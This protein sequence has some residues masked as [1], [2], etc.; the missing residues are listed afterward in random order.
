MEGKTVKSISKLL[1]LTSIFVFVLVLGLSLGFSIGGLGKDT[2]VYATENTVLDY[3]NSNYPTVYV[4]NDEELRAALT[5]EADKLVVVNKDITCESVIEDGSY[6]SIEPIEVV[7]NKI[8]HLNGNHVYYSDKTQFGIRQGGTEYYYKGFEES[9]YD[10]P[11]TKNLIIVNDGVTFTITDNDDNKGIL[12]FDSKFGDIS[13]SQYDTVRNVLYVKQGGKLNIHGGTIVAG[14]NKLIYDAQKVKNVT[15]YIMGSAI[16]CDGGNVVITGGILKG[17]GSESRN[18]TIYLSSKNNRST[19]YIENAKIFGYSGV[20][21]IY[22]Y[23]YLLHNDIKIVSGYFES[24]RET[25][26]ASNIYDPMPVWNNHIH[27]ANSPSVHAFGY[28]EDDHGH[29]RVYFT[30]PSG[31]LADSEH[32]T[33]NITSDHSGDGD[34]SSDWAKE[35]CVITPQNKELSDVLLNSEGTQDNITIYQHQALNVQ[36]DYWDASYWK[37][38]SQFNCTNLMKSFNGVVS[39][40]NKLKEY[41]KNNG[42]TSDFTVSKKIGLEYQDISTVSFSNGMNDQFP[43]NLCI[44]PG[45]EKWDVG[46]YRITCNITERSAGKNA[47]NACNT[48]TVNVVS[49]VDM[50]EFEDI[51]PAEYQ[52]NLGNINIG[53]ELTLKFNAKSKVELDNHLS[54]AKS[55]MVKYPNADKYVNA[56]YNSTLGTYTIPIDN[57]GYYSIYEII[58]LKNGNSVVVQKTR[59]M[60]ASGIDTT[61]TATVTQNPNGTI[62]LAN[63]FGKV[64]TKFKP[65]ETVYVNTTPNNSTYAV[66]SINVSKSKGGTVDVSNNSFVMPDDDVTV[67]VVFERVY[68][69]NYRESANAPIDETV[70]FN[71]DGITLKGKTY[72]KVGYKQVGWK[73]GNETYSLGATFTQTV[74]VSAIPVFEPYQY[75]GMRFWLDGYIV[76]TDINYDSSQNLYYTLPGDENFNPQYLEGN[77]IEYYTL[78]YDYTSE[79]EG[80]SYYEGDIFYPGQ[81]IIP[82]AD[83]LY[84]KA[85]LQESEIVNPVEIE[86]DSTLEIG[87]NDIFQVSGPACV[88]QELVD[89]SNQSV[90][91]KDLGSMTISA[92]VDITF[93]MYIGTNSGYKF[94]SDMDSIDIDWWNIE[95][96][97]NEMAFRKEPLIQVTNLGVGYNTLAIE[98]TL[99]PACGNSDGDHTWTKTDDPDWCIGDNHE[100]YTCSVCQKEKLVE[101]ADPGDLNV[102]QYHDLEWVSPTSSDCAHDVHGVFGH[103]EC[104][105]CG[106]YFNN[107]Y[108]EVSYDDIVDP[109]LHAWG[110]THGLYTIY[111]RQFEVHYYQCAECGFIDESSIGFHNNTNGYGP[112]SELCGYEIPCEHQ[113]TYEE[114][115]S[116]CNHKGKMTK[117]CEIC[118]DVQEE[119]YNFTDHTLVYVEAIESTCTVQGK[120]AYYVCSHCGLKFDEDIYVHIKEIDSNGVRLENLDVKYPNSEFDHAGE[121]ASNPAYAADYDLQQEILAYIDLHTITNPASLPLDNTK[122]MHIHIQND[123]A[124]SASA[125]GYS[126]DVY[127]IDCGAKL[128]DGHVIEKHTH[129]YVGSE[130]ESNGTHHWH[131][132]NAYDGCEEELDKAAHTYGD[133]HYV[134]YADKVGK[135]W[136]ECSVCGY[137][138]VEDYT[139]DPIVIEGEKNYIITEDLGDLQSE[140]GKDVRYIF[141]LASANDGSVTFETENVTIIFDKD[142]VKDIA[143]HDV[144]FKVTISKENLEGFNIPNA[145]MV[146]E[147]SLSGVTFANGKAKVV[148]PVDVQIPENSEVKVFYVNGNDKEDMNATYADSKISFETTHFSKYVIAFENNSQPVDPQPQPSTPEVKPND[149]KP[150]SGGAIAGI[151]IAC[152]VVLAGAGVGVFFLLKKKGIIGKK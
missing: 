116:T 36:L 145:Q 4:N 60:H 5:N 50:L 13:E 58:Q 118:G 122:H 44:K 75:D 45:S 64:L 51:Q 30:M 87:S 132:C 108:E 74:N 37:Y 49:S 63:V 1:L 15:A 67:T 79:I 149:K 148:V 107:Q 101:V 7:G 85:V 139:P 115:L 86:I 98:I 24:Y 106:K 34:S 46:E 54:L 73:I 82:M 152:V 71:S 91:L 56:N 90:S 62:L 3:S 11:H 114:D 128:E 14:R 61:K 43:L 53:T 126:G 134:K 143:G 12:Q 17:R 32:T 121:Y 69:L 123:V 104:R 23:N 151:V 27:V 146:I 70:V 78:G 19:L 38:H 40:A 42:I 47:T 25:N 111:G 6:T 120:A 57:L 28:S 52:A 112:C 147:L 81:K 22:S 142:A 29:E 119:I 100:H 18:S 65:G 16:V 77:H 95:N 133:W 88:L 72:T 89:K 83:N 127:C 109:E 39:D 55:V 92:N 110:F 10:K 76:Y 138:H 94:P 130:W 2:N 41:I 21:T 66:R 125:N 137:I 8:L 144:K 117:T 48:L 68:N 26:S 35:V 31:W 135:K 33:K 84:L 93:I 136:Q 9:K 150:L 129:S 80:I 124:V 113:W 102:Q 20:C 99:Y 103:Y 105:D 140:E 131:I 141:D 59:E 97:T 96:N